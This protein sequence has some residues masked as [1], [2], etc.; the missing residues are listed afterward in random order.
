L[1]VFLFKTYIG[2]MRLLEASS[3]EVDVEDPDTV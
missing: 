3:V 2:E 1:R